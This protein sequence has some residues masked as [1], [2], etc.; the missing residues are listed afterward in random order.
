[1]DENEELQEELTEEPEPE[2]TP[3]SRLGLDSSILDT[4]KAMLGPTA[5]YDAFDIDII[6]HINS[7]FERLC[8]LGVGPGSPFYIEDA[9]STWDEFWSDVSW[10]VIRYVVLYVKK[11]FDPT[12][13]ST[14][15]QSY[16]EELNKLEWLM[17]SV[18]EVGY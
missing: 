11:V 6:V 13:N 9:E 8:E 4:V 15:K 18:S 7:A 12:A 3:P 2:P 1:M 10:Q 16:E 14:I 17:N 5:D